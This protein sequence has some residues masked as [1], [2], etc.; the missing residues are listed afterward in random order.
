MENRLSLLEKKMNEDKIK[1]DIL[2]KIIKG[3]LKNILFGLQLHLKFIQL[4]LFKYLRISIIFLLITLKCNFFF[5]KFK[6]NFFFRGQN[7]YFYFIFKNP[8]TFHFFFIK[9]KK[10][11]DGG[12]CPNS[13][14]PWLVRRCLANCKTNNLL[15]N[16]LLFLKSSY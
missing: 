5:Q 15:G 13:H 16:I 7:L 2:S 12:I 11:I 10:K 9:M 14:V 4:L 1:R 3:L 8:L 6:L